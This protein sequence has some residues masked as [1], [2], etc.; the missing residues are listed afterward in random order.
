M[1][2]FNS[3]IKSNKVEA[4]HSAS[5]CLEEKRN[6]NVTKKMQNNNVSLTQN[7]QYSYCEYVCDVNQILM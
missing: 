6:E 7:F 4:F 3:Y 2:Y 5:H 1:E